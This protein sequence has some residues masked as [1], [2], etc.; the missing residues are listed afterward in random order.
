MYNYIY[1]NFYEFKTNLQSMCELPRVVVYSKHLRLNYGKH[2]HVSGQAL[3][4]K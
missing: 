1:G 3:S 2:P 4:Y